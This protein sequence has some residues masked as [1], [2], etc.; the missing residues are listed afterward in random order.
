LPWELLLNRG[1]V[2]VFNDLHK[3]YIQLS[4]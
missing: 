4:A 2:P 3:F 1:K